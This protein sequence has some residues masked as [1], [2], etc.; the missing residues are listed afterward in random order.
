MNQDSLLGVKDF[1]P[2]QDIFSPSNKNNFQ[3]AARS[4]LDFIRALGSSNN[5]VLATANLGAYEA[6]LFMLAAGDSGAP[7]YQAVTNVKS[8]YSSQ[9]GIITRLRA[10]RQLGL[11]DE[12]PGPKKSQVCL[13]PSH[14]LLCELGPLLLK[15]HAGT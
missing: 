1:V 13:T 8:R 7:V 14:K 12:L 5:L 11:I 10:M 15:R 9:S 3:A 4:E 2:M 6:L